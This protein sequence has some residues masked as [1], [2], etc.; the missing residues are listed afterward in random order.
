MIKKYAVGMVVLNLFC[1][2]AF[3]SCAL[4]AIGAVG[5]AGGYAVSS[6]GIEGVSDKSYEHLWQVAE[7]ILGRQGAIEFKDKE[8]GKMRVRIG[9]SQV[10]FSL[11]QATPHSVVARVQA[12]KIQ[13]MFPDIGLA[14]RLYTMIVKESK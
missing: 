14:R 1:G 4:L 12:R 2:L 11:E 7:D 13:G 6:D 5:V 10:K 8:Q 3:S 9:G